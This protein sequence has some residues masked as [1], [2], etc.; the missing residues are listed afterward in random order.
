MNG[1]WRRS[2]DGSVAGGEPDGVAEGGGAARGL[3]DVG[4]DLQYRSDMAAKRLSSTLVG[5]LPGG[6]S[7]ITP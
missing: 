2:C 7:P 3:D 1:E 5:A 6:G 4:S